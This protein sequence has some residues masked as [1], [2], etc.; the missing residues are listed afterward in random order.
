MEPNP[1]VSGQ[2]RLPT[3]DNC[4]AGDTGDRHSLITHE[5]GGLLTSAWLAAKVHQMPVAGALIV[6]NIGFP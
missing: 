6:A 3:R 2:S 1:R 5:T 4:P